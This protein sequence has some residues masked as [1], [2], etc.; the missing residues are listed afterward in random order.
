MEN[1]LLRYWSFPSGKAQQK[2]LPHL[3]IKSGEKLAELELVAEFALQEVYCSV[4]INTLSFCFHEHR[5]VKLSFVFLQ[6][7]QSWMLLIGYLVCIH[8]ELMAG[9]WKA[10]NLAVKV[11][12][13]MY[14][15]SDVSGSIRVVLRNDFSTFLRRKSYVNL[16][17]KSQ[18]LLKQIK[19]S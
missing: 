4:H 2:P 8:F 1:H 10:F 6:N 5:P 18:S 19:Y 7:V 9:F 17:L 14:S 3:H 15:L 16:T 11:Y 13:F 12:S